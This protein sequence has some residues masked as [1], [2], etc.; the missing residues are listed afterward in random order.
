MYKQT[1][2]HLSTLGKEEIENWIKSFDTVL[3][4]CDGIKNRH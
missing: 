3:C 2:T 1:G 4:D